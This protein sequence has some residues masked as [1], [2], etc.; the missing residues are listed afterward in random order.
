LLPII[1][2]LQVRT[3]DTAENDYVP[4]VDRTKLTTTISLAEN[5]GSSTPSHRKMSTT[6]KYRPTTI[7]RQDSC[8]LPGE[9][10]YTDYVLF[11]DPAN[12]T[13][14]ILLSETSIDSYSSDEECSEK[15]TVDGRGQVF[16]IV[17]FR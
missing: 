9:Y 6:T 8:R 16:V 14:T 5:T 13:M 7:K 1:Q 2:N 11:V 3:L 17:V 15:Q 4:F 12:L 10:W